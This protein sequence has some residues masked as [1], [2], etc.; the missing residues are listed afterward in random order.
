MA[1]LGS[2]DWIPLTEGELHVGDTVSA[3]AGGM[4]IYRVVA[5]DDGELWLQDGRRPSP[6][7]L[8]AD[9]FHWRAAPAQS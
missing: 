2:I 4:P 9:R 5:I 3:D 1:S 6:L 7:R 8:P